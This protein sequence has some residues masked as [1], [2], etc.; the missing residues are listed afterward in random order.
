MILHGPYFV[1][2]RLR[3]GD[4]NHLYNQSVA[5]SVR[6]AVVPAEAG[7]IIPSRVAHAAGSSVAV[8][9]RNAWIG[10]VFKILMTTR[11]VFWN[12][13]KPDSFPYNRQ[14]RG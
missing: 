13:G 5:S 9:H 4:D 14:G 3:N 2:K 8:E 11:V 12:R 7:P 1:G 10:S 6:R